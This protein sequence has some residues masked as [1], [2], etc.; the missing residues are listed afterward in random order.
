[1]RVNQQFIRQDNTTRVSLDQGVDQ[2]QANQILG[3]QSSS[4]YQEIPTNALGSTDSRPNVALFGH[5]SAKK[6][7]KSNVD[8]G[9]A[10][11][12]FL[13]SIDD[14]DGSDPELQVVGGVLTM[15][16]D[17]INKDGSAT[18]A[19]ESLLMF[20]KGGNSD[21]KIR[22]KGDSLV[23]SYVDSNGQKKTE[24]LSK[25]DLINLVREERK[26]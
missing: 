13:K 17:H 23:V 21:V 22:A 11:E 7:E 14:V 5:S 12:D 8:V 26:H 25:T 2:I 18:K 15:R 9:F 10:V 19:T 1:M 24:S 16:H 3:A 6:S 20:N 4:T